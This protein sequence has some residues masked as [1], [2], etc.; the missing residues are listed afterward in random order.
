MGKN[1]ATSLIVPL[2]VLMSLVSG[3]KDEEVAESFAY[4][5]YVQMDNNII[6]WDS[7][8]SDDGK[9]RV[10]RFPTDVKFSVDEDRSLYMIEERAKDVY[11]Y[12]IEY[13]YD[14]EKD[15]LIRAKSY[16]LPDTKP[17]RW[18]SFK[19]INANS[20]AK[21]YQ[22]FQNRAKAYAKK[23]DLRKTRWNK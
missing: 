17:R 1:L 11:E 12:R 22:K 13:R 9:S 6:P 3:C 4:P 19:R 5:S 18:E 21:Q 10:P 14:S 7:V 20:D 8:D 23:I 16:I 2:I 15:S